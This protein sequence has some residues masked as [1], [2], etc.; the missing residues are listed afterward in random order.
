MP[1]FCDHRARGMA[2]E[3]QAFGGTDSGC[4]IGRVLDIGLGL[5]GKQDHHSMDRYRS[6]LG[7]LQGHRSAQTCYL[8]FTYTVCIV[9]RT[10]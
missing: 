6:S 4:R 10:T 3:C 1:S 8:I 7:V 9:K 5:R 2:K